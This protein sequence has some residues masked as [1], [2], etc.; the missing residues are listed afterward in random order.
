MEIQVIRPKKKL[1]RKHRVCAYCRVS[2]GEV[3]LE[4]SLENQM[5]HY[6]EYIKA[7]PEY[8]MVGIF[9][10]FGISGFKEQRPGF[11]EMLEAARRKE[12]DLIITKS[13]SRFCRNTD[14]LLKTVRELK[15]LGVG[16]L[17]ELQ[18]INTLSESGEVML[19]VL[20]AF[21]QP[22]SDNY[23]ALAQMVYRRKFEAGIPVQ[24]LER[25]FG[26]TVNGEGEYIPDPEEAPWVKRIFELY[27][28]GH[29][30]Q[31]IARYLNEQGVKAAKGGD[32]RRTNVLHILENEIYKQVPTSRSRSMYFSSRSQSALLTT[33][34][35]SSPNSINLLIC[36]RKQ[37]QLC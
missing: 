3:E 34:A 2:S 22:E 15:E 9:H 11:Q 14:T 32:F 19:T 26:Y 30:C 31:Q 18:D 5:S 24:Q 35:L 25:C 12:I 20:A 27:A 37:S 21:A 13:V 8:E 28:E 4:N 6:E 16:V 23:R 1:I 17:F 10:D 33:I 7:N 29:N 36:L